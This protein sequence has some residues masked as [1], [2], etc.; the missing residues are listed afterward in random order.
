MQTD[1]RMFRAAELHKQGE[2]DKDAGYDHMNDALGYLV[3][4]DFSMLHAR[5]GR[6]TGYL[7]RLY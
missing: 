4:R 5:A 1:D 6:G 7:I 3:D 2:P